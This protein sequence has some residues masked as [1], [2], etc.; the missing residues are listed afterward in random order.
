MIVTKT[1][2]EINRDLTEQE[3]AELEAAE[4]MPIVFDEDCPELTPEQV[5]Q[6]KPFD[7]IKIKFN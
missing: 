2:D 3:K 7:S 5:K 4:K 1:W 6:F